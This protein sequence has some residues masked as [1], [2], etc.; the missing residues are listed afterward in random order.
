M[1]SRLTS[2]PRM[3]IAQMASHITQ[4]NAPKASSLAGRSLADLPKSWTFTSS[5]PPDPLFPTPAASHKTP[6]AEIGPRQVKGAL[7]TWVR[8]ENAIDPELLAV[9]P[10]AMKDLGIQEAQ[11][12]TEEFKQTVAG[13]QL[14]GWDEEKLEGGYPWAQCYGGWQF[15]SWAG[16][17]GDGR[18]ISLFETTNPTTN[19]RYELQLKGAGITPYS[20]FADGK[21][22]LR[23]SIREFI[24]SEALNGLKIPTTRALSLTLLPHS[25]VRRET[26]EPGAIVARFAESWLRI[27]TF[28]ILRAR[29]DRA[30]IRQLSTY[31]AEN[32]FEGWESLPARNP[33]DDGK[34]EA[35]ERGIS[36]FTIEGPTGLEE[37]RFTRLYREI[38]R[39][40]AMTVAAWQ[41]YAFTNGVLNTDNTSIFGLS[42][43]FGP[44]AF[45][46]NFDPSYTPNHDDYMLRYS[47]RN[48][49][50]IIWWNLVRLGESLGEL[51]GAGGDVDAEEFI[52]KGVRQEA[53]DELVA[54][55]EALITRIG[56][57]Y[58]A[59]FL[60]EYKR[61]M[62]AR[63]GL[64][65]FK[66]S[67]FETLFSE[68]L[69]TMESLELDFNQFFRKLSSIPISSLA[70]TTS[71]KEISTKFFHQ[72]GVTGLNNTLESATT[73]LTNWLDKWQARIYEDWGPDG[74][75]ENRM[76]EMKKVNPKFI[77]KGWVLDEIIKR[78]EKGG[79]RDVLNR[80]MKMVSDPFRESW[81]G[82]QEEEERWCGDVPR[83]GRAM[84][85][86]CSS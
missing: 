54:R 9:S 43:D 22:V 85:C 19:V 56:E 53:A 68:L 26:V 66:E 48:Q 76:S 62:T 50:T 84:Q 24:V 58:K 64:K 15:G 63:L 1:L 77:P 42:I 17:L 71:R 25:R 38:V 18:A 36:R 80:V 83:P 37:N 78:V 14:W 27:G 47:Y 7:F 67:D 30:L 33:A 44:F 69:D 8:P 3:R 75:D 41:A 34:V 13:N 82:D 51:M 23:S 21:A 5:L 11:G 61:L 86:S 65:T 6:R 16:Q 39:R 32:V 81:D 73:R 59:T 10:T 4:N 70:T 52:E 20:R 46:D 31:I 57:E 60:A 29:G 2:I 72:E 55:A 12:S 74:D 45:L 40:N 49:P 79:E 35:I 28:D